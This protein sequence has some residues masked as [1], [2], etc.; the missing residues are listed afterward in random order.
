MYHLI[1]A[2]RFFCKVVVVTWMLARQVGTVLFYFF[3][4]RVAV[5]IH[6]SP[7]SDAGVLFPAG[8]AAADN[9]LFADH[10]RHCPERGGD[11][12]AVAASSCF[13]H[14]YLNR[15]FRECSE[16]PQKAGIKMS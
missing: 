10:A 16:I 2:V 9:V 14:L 3:A 11:R 15:A 12:G 5:G 13:G 7:R 6:V 4:E 8:P 1:F